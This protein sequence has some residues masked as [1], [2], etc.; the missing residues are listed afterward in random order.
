MK[1]KCL[2]GASKET[3]KA[4]QSLP[5]TLYKKDCPQ[6]KK[7][8]KEILNGTHPLSPDFDIYPFVITDEHRKPICRCI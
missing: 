7:T 6:N 3:Q 1:Y 2:T 8:E 5:G 4:F